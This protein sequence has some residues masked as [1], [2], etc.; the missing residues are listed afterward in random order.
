MGC[1]VQILW[2]SF[3]LQ[4]ARNDMYVSLA[5]S[6]DHVLLAARAIERTSVSRWS[7][8]DGGFGKGY[9][10]RFLRRS[11]WDISNEGMTW[12]FWHF[13]DCGKEARGHCLRFRVIKGIG[14]CGVSM[15]WYSWC[16]FGGVGP[17]LEIGT[18]EICRWENLERWQISS[19]DDRDSKF[20]EN[21]HAEFRQLTVSKL[22]HSHG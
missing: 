18:G 2:L 12:K 1:T 14:G 15:R 9:P 17:W 5:H 6:Q 19:S 13:G 16:D 4:R 21:K 11:S 22:Q 8:I 7:W 20:G 10:F 3:Y